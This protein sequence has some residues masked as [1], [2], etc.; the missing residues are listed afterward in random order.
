MRIIAA[1]ALGAE[2]AIA[3]DSNNNTD[4]AQKTFVGARSNAG[5]DWN[6]QGHDIFYNGHGAL[7]KIFNAVLLI[8]IFLPFSYQVDL[9]V[10]RT[11]MRRHRRQQAGG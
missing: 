6:L 1:A 4:A 9:V 5:W 11:L 7:Q 3:R 2:V 10:Y 8:M